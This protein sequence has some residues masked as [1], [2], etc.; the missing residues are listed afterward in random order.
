MVTGTNFTGAD[1]R[2]ADIA[3]MDGTPIGLET[4][5]TGHLPGRHGSRGGTL[6]GTSE[7]SGP[8]STGTSSQPGSQPEPALDG[9]LTVSSRS[10][11]WASHATP[12]ADPAGAGGGHGSRSLDWVEREMADVRVRLPAFGGMWGPRIAD[13]RRGRLR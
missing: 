6:S 1:L 4:A 9:V 7:S 3:N 5:R 2:D 13:D 11:L 12:P 10:T 8:S